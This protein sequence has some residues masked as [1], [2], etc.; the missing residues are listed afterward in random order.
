MDAAQAA[1]LA[2]MEDR[3]ERV[4]S[5]VEHGGTVWQVNEP[6]P[7]D[8]SGTRIVKMFLLNG[9]IEVYALPE[10]GTQLS[11]LK[12]GLHFT[13]MPLTVKLVA[14]IARFDTWQHGMNEAET[15]FYA[16]PEEEDEEEEEGEEEEGQEEGEEEQVFA[17]PPEGFMPPPPA[18]YMPSPQQQPSS[19]AQQ[20]PAPAPNYMPNLSQ[21]AAPI[22]VQPPETPGS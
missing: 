13:L 3:K 19:Q 6:V 14:A 21:Q 22:P 10:P 16:P 1:E 20:Q 7:G 4:M 5:V 15:A 18:S 2:E 17:P 12:R 11:N 9:V 8:Q